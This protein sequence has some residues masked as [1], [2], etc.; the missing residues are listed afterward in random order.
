VIVKNSPKI[1]P[2]RKKKLGHVYLVV[3]NMQLID[4][5]QTPGYSETWRDG[6]GVFLGLGR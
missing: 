3:G 1:G 5:S 2:T 6:T 4:S